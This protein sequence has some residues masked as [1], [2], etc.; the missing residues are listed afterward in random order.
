MTELLRRVEDD[1]ALTG[2]LADLEIVRPSSPA[3]VWCTWLPER[4]PG[5]LKVGVSM[6]QLYWTRELTARAPDIFPRLLASGERLG[7]TGECWLLLERISHDGLGPAWRGREYQMVLESVLRFHL[8]ARSE[9]RQHLPTWDEADVRKQLERGVELGVPGPG[10]A[11]LGAFEEHWRFV[12]SAAEPEVCLMDV[13]LSNA[14][15][16]DEAPGGTALLIDYWPTLAPWTCDPAAFEAKHAMDGRRPGY[17][18]F[19]QRMAALRAEARL[20]VC[21]PE[22]LEWL[23]RIVVGWSAMVHWGQNPPL[24]PWDQY[25]GGIRSQVEAA[26]AVG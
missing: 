25:R 8:A 16:R 26:A 24:H 6:S 3:L 19:V 9:P 22:D 21:R 1:P 5:L 2:Q 4:L 13:Q 11:L 20:G 12:R 15:S 7:G 18:R 10:L 17:G 14:L 23:A